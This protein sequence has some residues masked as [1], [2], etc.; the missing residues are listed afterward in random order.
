M[1]TFLSII[2]LLVI[3]FA[4]DRI[5]SLQKDVQ[6]LREELY[7]RMSN[8]EDSAKSIE[9]D[10]RYISEDINQLSEVKNRKEIEFDS[11]YT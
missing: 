5:H 4:A 7:T 9:I 8:I 10:V 2:T 11:R 3:C 1:L 6:I